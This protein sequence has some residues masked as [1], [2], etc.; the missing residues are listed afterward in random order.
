ME[1]VFL[2][3]FGMLIVVRYAS[4]VEVE[5]EVEVEEEE[6]V[7]EATIADF[8]NVCTSLLL[9]LCCSAVYALSST[10]CACWI[11]P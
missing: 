4:E 9:P 2:R 1:R 6:E 5:V 11:G 8:V 10:V 7:G 3:R